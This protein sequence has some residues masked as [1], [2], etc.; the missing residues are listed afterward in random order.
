MKEQK[1][2]LFSVDL[3]QSIFDFSL[4]IWRFWNRLKIYNYKLKHY[5]YFGSLN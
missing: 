3:S 2:I 4:E 5:A 1:K